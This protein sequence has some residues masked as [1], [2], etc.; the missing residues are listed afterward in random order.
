[1]QTRRRIPLFLLAAVAL[2]GGVLV[3]AEG[4]PAVRR[5]ILFRE[6][7]ALPERDGVMA[8]VDLPPGSAEGRHTHAGELFGFVLAGSVELTVEG[9]AVQTL[10]AGAI[11][12]VAPG[13]IHDIANPGAV[14]ARTAVVLVSERGK[15]ISLP[16]S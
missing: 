9:E 5:T 11:Y 14:D 8:Y 2:V 6:P 10:S 15:P 16:V 1:M 4:P 7:V 12:H 3:G 13:R